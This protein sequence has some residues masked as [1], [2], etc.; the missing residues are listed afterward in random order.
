VLVD[1]SDMGIT[2]KVMFIIDHSIKEGADPR[3]LSR[4]A[5]SSSRSTQGR[6]INAGWAPH[7]DLE[8]I[9]GRHGLIEDVLARRG[10]PKP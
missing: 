5:C 6:R 4:A 8:P 9:G 7:L 10:S 2:P 1:P 3:T